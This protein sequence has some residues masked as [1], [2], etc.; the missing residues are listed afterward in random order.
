[1][2]SSASI[3][4]MTYT[5]V[6][7]TTYDTTVL[8]PRQKGFS[9]SMFWGS[10]T[11][12]KK[13]PCHIQKPETKTKQKTALKDLKAINTILETVK[14]AEWELQTG[15]RRL[16]TTRNIGGLKPEQK[17]TMKT[18]KLTR[19]SKAGGVDQY[20]YQKVNISLTTYTTLTNLYQEILLA[21]LISFANTCKAKRPNTLPLV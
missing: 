2:I 21:K 10:F 20:R 1:M 6:L 7:R 14:K 8:R 9:E 11:W 18:G 4:H 3:N 5:C 13:G 12:Y 16:R 17:Q 19:D 15:I